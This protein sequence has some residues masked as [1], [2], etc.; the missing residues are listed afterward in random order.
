MP[1]VL[2]DRYELQRRI[3]SGGMATVWIALDRRLGREVAV[4]VLSDTL[5]GDER[6][7]QRF[8][9]EARRVG[10]LNHPNI[11]VV[12]DFGV[13]GDA[14]FIVMEL[15]RGMPLRRALLSS[16]LTPEGTRSLA[17]GILSGLGH[18]HEAGILH[19]DIKPGNILLTE[20]RDAK[21]ADFGIAKSI[22]ET[23][24]I[25]DSGAVLGSVSYASPEQLSGD[26]LSPASDLYSL[27]C[28]LYEC[29][30]GRPPF[31]AD[32]LVTLV[33]RQQNEAPAPLRDV[34]PTAPPDLSEVIMRGLAK[35]PDHRFAT[36]EEMTA[37]LTRLPARIGLP[38]RYSKVPLETSA[39]SEQG[40]VTSG[41]PPPP[42]VSVGRYSRYARPWRGHRVATIAAV[43]VLLVSLVTL[44]ALVVPRSHDANPPAGLSPA[45]PGYTPML[46]AAHC[47]SDVASSG[48]RCESLIVPQDRNHP[49]G[50]QVRLLVVRAA[51]RTP[52]PAADPVLDLGS[53]GFA[54]PFSSA[55]EGPSSSTRLY[56]NYIALGQR[57]GVGSSPELTCPEEDVAIEAALALPSSDPRGPA[58]EVSAFA[59]CRKRLMARGI[60]PNDYGDDERAADVRDLLFALHLRKVNVLAGNQAS[61]VAYEVMRDEP[62]TISS[63][64]LE[65]PFS[66]SVDIDMNTTS[67]LVAALEM[68]QSLCD[69]DPN[70][71]RAFP[72]LEQRAEADAIEF[73]QHPVTVDV[74]AGQ[75]SSPIVI[76]AN[77]VV[78]AL[79]AAF[80]GGDLG[81]IASQIY[82]P[83]PGLV[84]LAVAQASLGSGPGLNMRGAAESEYCKDQFPDDTQ[85]DIANDEA[86][87]ASFPPFAGTDSDQL[88]A[89]ECHAWGVDSDDSNDFDPVASSIPVFITTGGVV[90][91]VDFPAWAAQVASGF[92]KSVVL[93]F[94]TLADGSV[95]SSAAEVPTPPC[96]SPL[97]LEF[98]RNP[99]RDLNVRSC[100][101]QSPPI[102]F[103]G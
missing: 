25:T 64:I 36:T 43:V 75:G 38:S 74:R 49:R 81:L 93:T 37:A 23:I 103:D 56:A 45:G 48:V 95:H 78:D 96:L 66:P 24:G 5:S 87:D 99:L 9:R 30:A 1:P 10:S 65:N 100:E 67:G 57:G 21:L 7:L 39:D 102:A 14:H 80:G 35:D 89:D 31:V 44:T 59:A 46:V 82:K 28:V 69:R 94:P 53:Y 73:Q 97:R 16:P 27:S 52:H 90:S 71:A 50:P 58:G 42:T 32:S 86:A 2:G 70:C 19:R 62:G 34:A 26:P 33:A 51:A 17:V 8:E 54:P 76:D 47:P 85:V 61:L 22:D 101:A 13:D 60:N 12:H 72:N 68:Y 20:S 92:T 55:F 3:G 6:F 88:D 63:V 79:V 11:V 4:K 40:S 91:S 15:V 77:R 18:A 41:S 84:A 83:Q 98:L 29:L